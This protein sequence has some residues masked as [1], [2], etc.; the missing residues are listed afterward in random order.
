MNHLKIEFDTSIRK[1]IFFALVF[2]ISCGVFITG[3]VKNASL[4]SPEEGLLYMP[5]AYQ[6]R[7]DLSLY[8]ITDTQTAY[9]GIAYTGFN[10]AAKDITANFVVD[11][12][13]IETYNELNAYTGNVY[14]PI[15][16]SAYSLSGLTTVLS[17]GKTSSQPLALN[18]LAHK[19]QFGTHYLL[20][21]R[22]LSVSDGTFDTTLD[23]AYFKIDTLLIRSK[24]I[25][26]HD[27]T[28]ASTSFTYNYDDAPSHSDNGESAI[29]LVDSN[30]TTKYLLFTFHPDMY[31]QLSYPQPTVVNAYAITSGGDAQERDP[32]SW[33]LAASNDGT[34]WTVIDTQ[35]NQSFPGRLQTIQFNTTNIAAYKYYR[36]NITAN[37]NNNSGLFQCTE[38]RLLQFY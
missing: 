6:E 21:I 33:N 1:K 20:P 10:S 3:C 29:H 26:N 7:A 25:T 2:F 11:N 9:F 23:I 35:T 5:Q 4:Y 27:S 19:L 37:N 36:W 16:D 31:V 24:D 14:Y 30:Y 17:A 38:F 32:K 8:Y 12:S 28:G 15:P 18:I 22:L 34:N 13:L